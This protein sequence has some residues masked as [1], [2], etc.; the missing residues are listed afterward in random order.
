MA[1]PLHRIAADGE[2]WGVRREIS[3]LAPATSNT[4]DE[5]GS[6]GCL[7]IGGGHLTIGTPSFSG[8]TGGD[9]KD[10]RLGGWLS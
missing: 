7:V 1:R 6:F 4:R 5:L 3:Y 9:G 8:G 2:T 10:I